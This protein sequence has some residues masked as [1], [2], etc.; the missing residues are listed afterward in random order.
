MAPRKTIPEGST[1]ADLAESLR[2]SRALLQLIDGQFGQL[3]TDLRAVITG[4]T[5][6]ERGLL[7]LAESGAK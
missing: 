5:N 2:D 4:L 7:A 1:A 3:R 6:L